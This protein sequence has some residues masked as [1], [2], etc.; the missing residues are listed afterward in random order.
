MASSPTPEHLPKSIPLVDSF[1]QVVIVYHFQENPL[2]KY[3]LTN[4]FL[5]FLIDVEVHRDRNIHSLELLT[6]PAQ[7]LPPSSVRKEDATT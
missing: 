4:V 3:L 7:G 2:Q 5:S 6:F 1:S